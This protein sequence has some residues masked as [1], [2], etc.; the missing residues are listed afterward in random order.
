MFSGAAMLHTAMNAVRETYGDDGIEVVHRAFIERA[1][2]LGKERAI[3][4]R[5][6]SL[7]AYCSALESGCTGTH[8]WHKVEDTDMRKAYIFI[9]CMWADIFRELEAEDIGFWICEG[10]GP[11]V[12][13][14]NPSIGFKRTRTLM[15]GD[16][17][18]DHIYF[19]K[20]RE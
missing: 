19:Y 10:D 14:F 20:D 16:G 5:D 4:E 15:Q 3:K 11:S 2:Q 17:C 7:H 6:N 13:A 18:C 1:V 9:Y 8:K 12:E